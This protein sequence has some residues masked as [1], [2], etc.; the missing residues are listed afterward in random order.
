MSGDSS[1]REGSKRTQLKCLIGKA[2]ELHELPM[3]I[4]RFKMLKESCT[5]CWDD[6]QH[7]VGAWAEEDEYCIVLVWRK[8]ASTH[9]FLHAIS[10]CKEVATRIPQKG[11]FE[12]TPITKIL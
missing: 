9:D 7:R 10:C 8:A 11:P 5:F 3:L 4:P 12:T 6:I 2:A 1:E